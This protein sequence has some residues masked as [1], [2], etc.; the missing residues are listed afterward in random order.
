MYVLVD[1]DKLT[2][3]YPPHSTSYSTHFAP[4]GLLPAPVA[5]IG[6]S[7][8]S[9]RGAETVAFLNQRDQNA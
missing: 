2:Y 9:S 1:I 4:F 8:F 5:R 3:L 6:S 7:A